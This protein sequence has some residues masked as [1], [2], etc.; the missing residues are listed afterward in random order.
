M[1]QGLF[2]IIICQR[3]AYRH[4]AARGC[5]RVAPFG[6][7]R[8]LSG[9]CQRAGPFGNSDISDGHTEPGINGLSQLK[10][11]FYNTRKHEKDHRQFF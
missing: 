8:T 6:E 1:V 4:F 11:E 10:T 3:R 2:F 9:T 7:P 5:C